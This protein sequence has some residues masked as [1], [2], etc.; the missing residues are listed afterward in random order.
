MAFTFEYGGLGGGATK[1]AIRTFG[2]GSR[3]RG[4]VRCG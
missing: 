4:I 3:Y 2:I 1:H